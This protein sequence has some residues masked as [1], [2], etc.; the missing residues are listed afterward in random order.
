MRMGGTD[1]TQFQLLFRYNRRNKQN[2]LWNSVV[3]AGMQEN[4]KEAYLGF[5]D[6][7][8]S[9]YDDK[10]LATGY[11]AYIAMPLL[12]KGWKEDMTQ[13]EAVEL[14]K[15]CMSV[16]YYRDART[17]NNIQ[18][19]LVTSEGIDVSE[20]FALD[21]KWDYDLFVNP[22]PKIKPQTSLFDPNE[23]VT[24]EVELEG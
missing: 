8:G 2:P 20:P 23:Q 10:Y 24:E 7:V 6:L 16:L 14:I 9:N 13:D 17:I 4:D 3:V 11:G 12:R 1:I 19:V 22:D 18:I 5:V 15:K 21:T